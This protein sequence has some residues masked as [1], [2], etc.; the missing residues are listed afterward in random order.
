[1]NPSIFQIVAAFAAV[2]LT[3]YFTR[4]SR[5]H[6][7]QTRF[8]KFYER[9]S[10]CTE[11]EIRN[12]LNLPDEVISPKTY[13]LV[14]WQLQLAESVYHDGRWKLID[15]YHRRE[16]IRAMSSKYAEDLNAQKALTLEGFDPKF[17]KLMST[18]SYAPNQ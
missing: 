13:V 15:G 2:A 7:V 11:E 4:T 3:F 1:M 14:L 16:F 6:A 5:L 8:E 18:N 12:A 17:I 10:A 9:L